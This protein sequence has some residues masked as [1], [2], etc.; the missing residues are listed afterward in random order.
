MSNSLGS[1]FQSNTFNNQTN[2]PPANLSWNV[3]TTPSQFVVSTPS[4]MAHLSSNYKPTYGMNQTTSNQPEAST[5]AP[6]KPAKKKLRKFDDE[7]VS[8]NTAARSAH[9][10]FR[11]FSPIIYRGA[12]LR[13]ATSI[14]LDQL[15]A[16]YPD[17][18]T[19]F[20][21]VYDVVNRLLPYHV[22][23][24][25]KSDP[26]VLKRGNPVKGKG[27]A[28]DCDMEIDIKGGAHWTYIRDAL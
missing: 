3:I 15:S 7:D 4:S 23:Q 17:V 12:A 1:S 28:L 11:Y 22:F 9:I 19:P 20:E 16:L 25:P 8:K 10:P 21:D 14:A 2:Q 24:H 26:D 18:E 27:K 6:K 13:F 5:S